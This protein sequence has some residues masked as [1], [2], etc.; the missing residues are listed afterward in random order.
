MFIC[1]VCAGCLVEGAGSLRCPQGHSFDI[2]RQG[3]VSLIT[4]SGT[5]AD[6]AEMVRARH[7]FLMKG[8]YRPIAEELVAV[9]RHLERGDPPYLLA[10]LGGGTGW[11]SQYLLDRLPGFEGVLFDASIYA[12]RIAAKAH[13]RLAVATTDLWR[14]IPLPDASVTLALVIFS[15][16][17]PSEIARILRQDGVCLVVTP[18]PNHLVELRSVVPLLAIEP[19]KDTRLLTQFSRFTPSGVTE[20]DYTIDLSP[21]DQALVVGMGPS[22]Y[23]ISPEDMRSLATAPTSVTVSVRIHHMEHPSTE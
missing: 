19:E 23:H 5:K 16:R 12:A 17:N 20:I 11:Y 7:S 15:P 22:A 18:G 8:F 6:T 10:D 1:P 21:D 3:Y 4:G 13:P 9:G 14:S 2:A